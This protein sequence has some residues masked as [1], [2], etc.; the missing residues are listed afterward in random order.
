MA[1]LVHQSLCKLL[2]HDDDISVPIVLPIEPFMIWT[3]VFAGH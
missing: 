2:S 1:T 3:Q